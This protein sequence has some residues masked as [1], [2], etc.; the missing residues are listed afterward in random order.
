MDRSNRTDDMASVASTNVSNMRRANVGD[1]N[2]VQEGIRM[3][4]INITDPNNAN[5]VTLGFSAENQETI[6]RNQDIKHKFEL[7]RQARTARIPTSDAEIQSRL[8]QLQ[9]PA[10]LLNENVVERGHRLMEA[11]AEYVDRENKMP[12]FADLNKVST[13][14]LPE[15]EEF[16]TVGSAELRQ[17]RLEI[18]KYSIPLSSYR[19]EKSRR[20]RLIQDRLD[21]E[22]QYEEY[23]NSFGEYEIVASQYADERCVSRGDLSYDNELYATSGWSGE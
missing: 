15:D 18:A 4:N 22:L 6:R 14:T 7:Q 16:Y 10:E 19:L 23:I 2:A 8:R 17:A 5:T 20:Q 9:Q 12:S 1:N 3:G 21:E 13:S 11:I